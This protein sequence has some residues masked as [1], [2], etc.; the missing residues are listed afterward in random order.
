MITACLGSSHFQDELHLA[1]VSVTVLSQ[2]VPSLALVTTQ[3]LLQETS[4]FRFQ[5]LHWLVTSYNYRKLP[6]VDTPDLMSNMKSRILFAKDPYRFNFV[7][8]PTF[9]E[10][11]WELGAIVS[12]PL[13]QVVVPKKATGSYYHRAGS[14]YYRAEAWTSG[15]GSSLKWY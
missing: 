14:R 10:W 3:A 11:D 12:K 8:A 4:D 13:L 5:L 1:K 6:E 7:P 15:I 9:S 2:Q